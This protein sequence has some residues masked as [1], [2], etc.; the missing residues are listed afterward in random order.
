MKIEDVQQISE[1]AKPVK[2]CPKCG[3][4]MAANHYWYKGGWKCKG[5][6]K[7]APNTSI[8]QDLTQ[9][10]TQEPP[11]AVE[12][13]MTQVQAAPEPTASA[14]AKLKSSSEAMT[15]W[16]TEHNITKFQVNPETGALT[17]DQ[18]VAL[19]GL[20]M[21]ALPVT[22][23]T[24]KDDFVVSGGMLETPKGSPR[25]VGGDYMANHN[26][27]TS[28]V[29]GPVKVHEAC[30]YTGNPITS[31]EGAPEYIGQTLWLDQCPELTS[32]HNIH[33]YIKY[34]GQDISLAEKTVVKSNVLGLLLIKGLK[35][36]KLDSSL[37]KV[38]EII[39]KHLEGERDFVACQDELIDAGFEPFARL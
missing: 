36:V 27:I 16:L 22:F 28:M 10:A 14:P 18:E 11:Q 21:K 26:Q 33:K 30:S 5:S 6:T 39:N 29:G 35:S 25:E 13:P 17:V 2:L 4:S 9:T 38:A 19:D 12:E 23:D 1:M 34:I 32:L 20:R 3:K 24:V 8:L 15:K 7:A 37:S 31:L